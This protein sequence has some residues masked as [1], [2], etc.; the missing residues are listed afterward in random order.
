[1]PKELINL[2]K[3]H[4]KNELKAYALRQVRDKLTEWGKL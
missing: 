4:P 2:H 3:P 1:M